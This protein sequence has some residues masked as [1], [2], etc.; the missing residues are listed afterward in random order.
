MQDNF[1]LEYTTSGSVAVERFGDALSKY[2]G[3]DAGTM[4]AIEKTLEADPEMPMALMFRA[5]LLKLAADPKFV[6]AIDRTS[7]VLKGRGDLT[8]REQMHRQALDDWQQNRMADACQLF[9]KIVETYPRDIL[10][11]RIAH[12]LHFYGDGAE[13]MLASLS[14]AIKIWNRSDEY[15]GYLKGMQ[16]FALEELGEYE[17]A[18]TAGRE[19]IEINPADVWATHAVTHILQMQERYQEGIVFVESNKSHWGNL[20][21]FVNHMHWHQALQYIGNNRLDEALRIYD[22]NLVDPIADD[23]YL[24]VCNSA[25][26][27]WRLTMLGIDVGDRWHQFMQISRTRVEDDELIFPTLH[28]L[29]APAMLQDKDAMTRCLSNLENWSRK[30]ETQGEI[31][32]DVGK[33]MAEAICRIGEGAHKAGAD[34][35]ASVRHDIW[36]IGGSHAQRHLFNQIIEHYA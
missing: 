32:R 2:L 9:D 26:L 4:P 16:C 27:L 21:N 7:T 14:P 11:L 36:R 35:L 17:T 33:T 34:L 18:E 15:F 3:S 5:Y 28:Y 24:D 30:R 23:F 10:A 29:M 22:E 8:E 20:N 6:P 13:K 31:C 19:A 25:S 12:Y 1:G